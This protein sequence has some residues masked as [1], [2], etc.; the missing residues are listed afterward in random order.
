MHFSRTLL[1]AL[2][3]LSY[4]GR[5]SGNAPIPLRD[6][7]SVVKASP[8]YLSKVLQQL[9]RVG[10]LNTVMGP[11]GGYCLA[12]KPRDITLLEVVEL[13]GGPREAT[14]RQAA[15]DGRGKVVE[16]LHWCAEPSRE[17]L[18]GLTVA[19]LAKSIGRD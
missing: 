2:D 11:H 13:F 15:D 1:I 7:A 12:R 5:V 8:T 4:I 17:R 19:D 16:M 9:A 18:A 6:I 3:S 10:F 14:T